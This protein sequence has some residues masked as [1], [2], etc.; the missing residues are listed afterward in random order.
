R[1]RLVPRMHEPSRA[2]RG[3]SQRRSGTAGAGQHPD[4]P[5]LLRFPSAINQ[6]CLP[7]T[8][9]SDIMN[10]LAKAFTASDVQAGDTKAPARP[11]RMGRLLLQ[12]GKVTTSQIN[13]IIALQAKE[14]LRFGEAAVKLG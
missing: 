9:R 5:H 13:A 8:S 10:D 4:Q 12:T 6:R 3:R 7:A 2:Q 11:L 1:S 14:D